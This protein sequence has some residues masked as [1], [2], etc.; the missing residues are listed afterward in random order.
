[1][2][3][4]ESG[5]LAA[6]GPKGRILVNGVSFSIGQGESLA[7]IGETGSGKTMIA[8]S[9][10]GLLPE[11]VRSSALRGSLNGQAFGPR[12]LRHL[13]GQELAYIPQNGGEF[14]APSRRV[15][16]QLYDSLCRA[17]LPRHRWAKTADSLL[18]AVGFPEPKAVLDQYTFQLSGGMAQRVTIA[19]AACGHA[20]LLL[21][22]EPTNGL[23]AAGRRRFWSLLQELFP[24]AAILL[25]THDMD[26]ASLCSRV[27]VLCGGQ[28]LEQGDTKAVLSEPRHPYTRALL[29]ARVES[30]M[31]ESPVLRARSGICPFSPRCSGFTDACLAPLPIQYANGQ[32]WRCVQ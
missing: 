27:L 8:R 28:C 14:L 19:L 21:A 20:R 11:D 6:L 9:I 30:G 23:D 1:M 18:C 25:I 5:T 2:F 26:A 15:R 31:A 16:Q 32:E 24:Q 3:Q 7:L 22:D 12:G 17:G 29:A 4:Y 13:L 10:M